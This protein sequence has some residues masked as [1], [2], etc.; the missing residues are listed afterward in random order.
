MSLAGTAWDQTARKR[1]DE[2][3][4]AINTHEK[5]C[6]IRWKTAMDTMGEIKRILAWATVSLLSCMIGLIAFLATHPPK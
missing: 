6:A 3:M 2:A 5:V 1:A 4:E